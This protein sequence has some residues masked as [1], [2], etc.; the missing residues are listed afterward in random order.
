MPRIRHLALAGAMARSRGPGIRPNRILASC[1]TAGA[2]PS[3]P[4]H[5][6]SAEFAP[7]SP[8]STD[9]AE[10]V[11]VARAKDFTA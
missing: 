3:S 8:R 2:R 1:P 11:V 7:F 6:L 5:L 9:Q 10:W 4:L